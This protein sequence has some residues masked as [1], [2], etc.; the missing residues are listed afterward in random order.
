MAKSKTL[1]ECGRDDCPGTTGASHPRNVCLRVISERVW[2]GRQ[3]VNLERIVAIGD[4]RI[5]YRIEVDSY[6]FQSSAKAELWNGEK[7]HR[8]HFIP[9][10]E[11]ATRKNV[12]YVTKGV[13]AKAFAG[14]LAELER[15]T[16]A[17][18]S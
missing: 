5:R 7:W 1:Y 9:G 10:P 13:T 11:L 18:L 15:V 17:V 4:K 8:V 14:D 2:Y 12:S 3:S 16:R 6:D